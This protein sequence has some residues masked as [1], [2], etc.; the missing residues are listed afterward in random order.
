MRGCLDFVSV[1]PFPAFSDF[2]FLF[3]VLS[4]ATSAICSTWL[5]LAPFFYCIEKFCRRVEIRFQIGYLRDTLLHPHRKNS[6]GKQYYGASQEGK[7]NPLISACK[8]FQMSAK[9]AGR[10]GVLVAIEW[11]VYGERPKDGYNWPKAATIYQRRL[12][13]VLTTNIV[14]GGHWIRKGMGLLRDL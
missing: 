10:E 4:P 12:P 2:I 13:F 14:V 7:G 1:P 11:Q 9:I 3:F 6:P 5:I 8:A